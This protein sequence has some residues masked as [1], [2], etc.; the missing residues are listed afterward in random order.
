MAAIKGVA[1]T[2]GIQRRVLREEVREHLVEAIL[3]G[4]IPAGARIIETHVAQQLGVSQ[5]PVREALRDLEMLGFVVSSA[6]R[7]TQ[8]RSISNSDLTQIYPIRAALE[9][10]AARAVAARG[11]EA[12]LARL[13]TLLKSMR[14]AAARGDTH[15]ALDADIAFHQT[16][17]EASGNRLLK[18]IWD[19]IRF[20]T[21]TFVTAAITR[22]PLRQLAD[23]HVVV[24]GALE[25]KDPVAAEQAM[26]QHI[27]ELGDWIRA[28][29][30]D[31]SSE[32]NGAN[33]AEVRPKR[34]AALP[35]ARRASTGRNGDKRH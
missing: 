24:L 19:S 11:D 5:A 1:G 17:V 13:R 18:Q 20:D 31:E 3:H 30:S 32:S 7:G 12:T 34:A 25:A 9:G 28:V 22:R 29:T 10:V 8:V 33:G 27:E 14:S 35:R 23:R 15:A 4:E 2:K 6:F 21:T 16:I 26:R